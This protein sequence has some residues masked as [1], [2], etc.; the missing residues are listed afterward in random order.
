[1]DFLSGKS[2]KSKCCE[3]GFELQ[4]HLML[5]CY[6]KLRKMGCQTFSVGYEVEDFTKF[7]DVVCHFEMNETKYLFPIQAKFVLKDEQKIN[8][9]DFINDKGRINLKK[10]IE[11]IL[12]FQQLTEGREVRY[13][14]ATT[15]Q[16]KMD[17]ENIRFKSLQIGENQMNILDL[18]RDSGAKVLQID[19]EFEEFKEVLQQIETDLKISRNTLVDIINRLIFQTEVPKKD[20]FLGII[21]DLLADVDVVN[22][23]TFFQTFQNRTMNYIKYDKATNER[24]VIS[25][26]A[27]NVLLRGSVLEADLPGI[28]DSFLSELKLSVEFESHFLEETWKSLQNSS[29][30]IRCEENLNLTALRV[31]HS[32]KMAHGDAILIPMSKLN[33][34]HI[35]SLAFCEEIERNIVILV[36]KK[37]DLKISMEKENIYFVEKIQDGKLS[38]FSY[39][40][41]TINAKQEFE[42]KVIKIQNFPLQL[43]HFPKNEYKDYKKLFEK[44]FFLFLDG[45]VVEIG[46]KIPENHHP[47]IERWFKFI[48]PE[49][50][51]I[52]KFPFI[53]ENKVFLTIPKCIVKG[54]PGMGKSFTLKNMMKEF[55]QKYPH[56]WV[57]FVQ[58]NL[59]GGA[60]VKLKEKKYHLT[61]N[62]AK[63]FLLNEILSLKEKLD[64]ELIDYYLTFERPPI[65]LIFDGF[66]EIMPT[67]EEVVL[68]F[69]QKLIGLKLK[70]VI[71]GRPHCER[72]LKGL[73]DFKEIEIYF[74]SEEQLESFVQKYYE[75][76]CKSCTSPKKSHKSF[77]SFNRILKHM[78]KNSNKLE[79][80]PLYLK[81]LSDIAFNIQQNSEKVLDEGH[82]ID[83]LWIYNEIFEL[84]VDNYLREK[85]GIDTSSN[86]AVKRIERMKK[87]FKLFYS[88]VAAREMNIDIDLPPLPVLSVEEIIA[89]GFLVTFSQLVSND[90]KRTIANAN[91]FVFIHRTFAEYFIALTVMDNLESCTDR[92]VNLL[93]KN[94]EFDSIF[95]FLCPLLSDKINENKI[96]LDIPQKNCDERELILRFFNNVA[97]YCW[98]DY[99]TKHLKDIITFL[100]IKFSQ[101]GLKFFKDEDLFERWSLD[102]TSSTAIKIELLYKS[103][104]EECSYSKLFEE[105]SRIGENDL[106]KKLAGLEDFEKFR[107]T[108]ELVETYCNSF[109]KFL[110]KLLEEILN[111]SHEWSWFEYCDKLFW[112]FWKIFNYS[113]NFRSFHAETREIINK[114]ELDRD[115]KD[116]CN[117]LVTVVSKSKRDKYSTFEGFIKDICCNILCSDG[118]FKFFQV[119]N[120]RTFVY[121]EVFTNFYRIFENNTQKLILSDNNSILY[122]FWIEKEMFKLLDFIENIS[123]KFF[124]NLTESPLFGGKS[125]EEYYKE[126][127]EKEEDVFLDVLYFWYIYR[128][129]FNTIKELLCKYQKDTNIS[130]AIVKDLSLCTTLA[131]YAEY[132]TEQENVK[133][134][135]KT[136]CQ[137]ILNWEV[138]NG[139]KINFLHC[140]AKINKPPIYPKVC[141]ETHQ[142]EFKMFEWVL[143]HIFEYLLKAKEHKNNSKNP[144]FR[145]LYERDNDGNI[146][147]QIYVLQNNCTLLGTIFANIDKGICCDMFSKKN[148]RK[149]NFFHCFDTTTFTWSNSPNSKYKNFFKTLYSSSY[150]KLFLER[151][152]DGKTPFHSINFFEAPFINWLE[153]VSTKTFISLLQIYDKDGNNIL[154][155]MAK[156]KQSASRQIQ[157]LRK[158]VDGSRHSHIPIKNALKY[159]NNSNE[160]PL[161]VCKDCAYC[162]D[163]YENCEM[164]KEFETIL[165][166]KIYRI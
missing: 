19:P 138:E 63:E 46:G 119:F 144:L 145:M 28:S 131:F 43:K 156:H 98:A 164:K 125:L 27:F 37:M 92:V 127:K 78:M 38:P 32:V 134:I 112:C 115:K 95:K 90:T 33:D 116:G 16:M 52:D 8:Q 123:D 54:H 147:L 40:E 104:N 155:Y 68:N 149:Q 30:F 93:N 17:M 74:Y 103:R 51:K 25:Q 106:I 2:Y 26:A 143:Y 136:F 41:L 65:I 135:I 35:K 161:D 85:E 5:Y 137:N 76:K 140:L 9:R 97:K 48:G 18:F 75:Y 152:I 49:L 120:E 107:K 160:T 22:R 45:K 128:L 13:I 62:D 66:D 166:K 73:K 124:R 15:A 110:Q 6:A 114:S 59:L 151:D 117:F 64:R 96:T 72:V 99:S 10:H 58:L 47:H 34:F 31:W 162:G 88:H 102:N 11:G 4:K 158:H 141:N 14:I 129:H 39:D 53:V 132:E 12:N 118:I 86:L 111:P 23:D 133:N 87:D 71:S 91:R 21:Q 130:R 61:E 94:K 20:N 55:K 122:H 89:P 36:D 150:D 29:K 79:Q 101:D 126:S 57:E 42:E 84:S 113:E 153:Y 109:H 56:F 83:I 3:G 81:L 163:E 148:N 50:Y 165:K 139:T 82:K 44:F 105:F 108:T 121:K 157:P 7:D 146:P 77:E 142:R 24:K 70:I 67:Y 69:I 159:K 60:F 100:D 154:H 80:F 1:M